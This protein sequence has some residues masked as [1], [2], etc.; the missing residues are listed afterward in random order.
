[1][2]FKVSF[3]KRYFRL[4]VAVAIVLCLSP[5][6]VLG[7][8]TIDDSSG[9][10]TI[11]SGTIENDKQKIDDDNRTLTN[12]GTIEFNANSAVQTT[13]GKSGITIINNAGGII[14]NTGAANKDY[15]IKGQNQTNFIF[16]LDGI[17]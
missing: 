8:D 4:L 13:N 3:W 17:V 15:A 1:M 2:C 6:L 5:S 16:L 12:S 14:A 9:D 11:S 7:L 10:K